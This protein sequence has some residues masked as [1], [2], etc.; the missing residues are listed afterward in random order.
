M[1]FIVFLGGIVLLAFVFVFFKA[2][3]EKEKLASMSPAELAAYVFGGLN[4]HLICPHCQTKGLVRVKQAVRTVTSTGK[5]G[6]ILKT[7]TTSQTQAVVTQH[8]C[9]QC[10]STWDI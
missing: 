3:H 1:G 8:H 9:D 6:G 5:V 10:A 2:Q 4:E 7:N